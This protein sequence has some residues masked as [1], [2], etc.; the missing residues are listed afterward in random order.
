M[1]LIN[2]P[3]MPGS[4]SISLSRRVASWFDSRP[5]SIANGKAAVLAMWHDIL[6]L[7]SRPEESK[8]SH[9]PGASRL[10]RVAGIALAVDM[11]HRAFPVMTEPPGPLRN[12]ARRARFRL[13]SGPRCRVDHT[14]PPRFTVKIRLKKLAKSSCQGPIATSHG[15]GLIPMPMSK[16]IACNCSYS[17]IRFFVYI[18]CC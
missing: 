2:V 7:E 8:F 15:H 3:K 13:H 18:S 12:V 6:C 11:R 10:D 16:V 4:S 17:H 9:L 1:G 5:G 14:Q